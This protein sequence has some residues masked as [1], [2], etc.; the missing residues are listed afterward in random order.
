M[1][2]G[3]EEILASLMSSRSWCQVISINHC[4]Q[5]V[6]SVKMSYMHDLNCIDD[7]NLQLETCKL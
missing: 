2:K 6:L 1:K 5:V 7:L 4:R 3:I